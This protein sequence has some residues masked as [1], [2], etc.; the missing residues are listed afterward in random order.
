MALTVPQEQVPH[1]GWLLELPDDKIEQFLSLLSKTGPQFNVYDLA[2]QISGKLQLPAQRIV[3]TLRVL[4]SLYLTRNFAQP[5]EE[6]VDKDVFFALKGVN[7]LAAEKNGMQWPKLRKFLISAL[8]FERTL[9]T[10]A[11]AGDVLTQHER[12][13]QDARI[14]TDLRPIFHVNV[15]EKPD[16]AVI[17]HML[18]ITQRGRGGVLTDLYFA[19]DHND[20]VT[21]QKLIER[22]LK[23]EQTLRDEMTNSGMT[24]LDP[25]LYF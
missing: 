20:V 19:L 13:F 17:I 16:A 14:M 12:I 9:G 15:S 5:I 8:S 2:E 10:A 25:K 1:V 4:A 7:A 3:G 6:F 11:K 23:K 21:M 18:K 24:V 22:A